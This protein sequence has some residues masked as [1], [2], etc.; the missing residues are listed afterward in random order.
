[1]IDKTNSNS[2]V[3]NFVEKIDCFVKKGEADYAS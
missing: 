3:L 2:I 1:M